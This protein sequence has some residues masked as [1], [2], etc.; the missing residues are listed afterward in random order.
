[1]IF[2]LEA[3][4]SSTLTVRLKLQDDFPLDDQGWTVVN[5]PRTYEGAIATSVRS[6]RMR[7]AGMRRRFAFSRRQPFSAR[8]SSSGAPSYVTESADTV[9]ERLYDP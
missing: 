8:M 9:R 5:P 6:V 7:K 4:E 2:R 3:K 1:M